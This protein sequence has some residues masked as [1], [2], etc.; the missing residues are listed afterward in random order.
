MEK[1]LN[2]KLISYKNVTCCIIK[3]LENEEY[4]N[5]ENLF[6]D[7]QEI[8][9]KINLLKYEGEK[10]KKISEELELIKTEIYLG[11]LLKSKKEFVSNEIRKMSANRNASRSYNKK[12]NVD[13][14]FFNKKI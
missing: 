7:R 11:E 3:S 6:S 8:I 10:F 1:E 5:L 2:E 9:D 14:I 12:F 13:S 4:D